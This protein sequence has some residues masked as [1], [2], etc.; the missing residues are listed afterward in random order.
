MTQKTRRR[1]H[2]VMTAAEANEAALNP[3]LLRSCVRRE[4]CR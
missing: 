3:V 2:R 4:S 1:F